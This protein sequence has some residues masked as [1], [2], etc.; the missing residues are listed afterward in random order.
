MEK[1]K[2]G[3][4]TGRINFHNFSCMQYLPWPRLWAWAPVSSFAAAAE[5]AAVAAARTPS[6]CSWPCLAQS[7]PG[8][9]GTV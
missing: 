2:M 9:A 6:A 4:G 8:T 5:I 7:C 1:G 3:K